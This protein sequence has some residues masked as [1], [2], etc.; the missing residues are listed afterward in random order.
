MKKFSEIKKGDKLYFLFDTYNILQE[1][2]NSSIGFANSNYG[3]V[4][5]SRTVTSES[6]RWHSPRTNDG[7]L[8]ELTIDRPIYDYKEEKV[9]FNFKS[10]T[11]KEGYE[12]CIKIGT[13]D[14]YYSYPGYIF[15]TKEGL[16]KKVR[17]ITDVAESN[18]NKINNSIAEL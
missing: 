9:I 10:I 13:S 11:K 17:Q 8:L 15:T 18:L 4:I 16:E 14:G 6:W 5:C 2:G 12:H 1:Y 7:L 3:L